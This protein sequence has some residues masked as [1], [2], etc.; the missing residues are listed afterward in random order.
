MD[1][2]IAQL[3]QTLD[4]IQTTTAFIRS[5]A[6]SQGIDPM[7]MQNPDGTY[8]MANVVLAKSQ[9]LH[10]LV[11]A[12]V[13]KKKQTTVIQNFVSASPEPVSERK[14]CDDRHAPDHGN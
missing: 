5:Q 10:A 11:E 7:A 12:Y 13:W 1:E 3:E 2:L 14:M 9:V 6:R 4:E 8:V